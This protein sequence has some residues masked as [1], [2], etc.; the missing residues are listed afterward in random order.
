MTY[1]PLAN[2]EYAKE[3][4]ED[5][6]STT[7]LAHFG[8][9]LDDPDITNELINKVIPDK[10]PDGGES[11]GGESEGESDEDDL[12]KST[13]VSAAAP[14]FKIARIV[15][16]I[17]IFVIVI[18]LIA[19]SVVLI[20]TSPSCPPQLTWWQTAVIYQVY[21]QS[22][23][24]TDTDENIT[25][26]YGDLKGI[27]SRLDYLE[28]TLGVTAVWINPIYASPMVDNGYD[29]SDY[30][31]I[32]PL[33]G[34]MQDFDTLLDELH[35]R[36]MKLIMD[37]V[38]NHTSDQHQWFQNCINT[39][40][41]E[42]CERYVW[43]E[44]NSDGGPPNNWLS[45]FNGSAWNYSEH[46]Q[47]YYLHQFHSEQPDLNHR[48]KKV[49][50]EMKNVLKFWLDKGVDGFRVDAVPFLLEDLE[51]R[52]EP[53]NPDFNGSNDSD[54]NSLQHIYTTNVR[55]VH[56]IIEDWRKTVDCYSEPEQE[57]VFIGEVYSDV[58]TVMDYYGT[59]KKEFDFPFN[60]FLIGIQEWNATT[61]R[62]AVHKWWYALPNG[63][64]PNW[65]LGNHDNPRI[66]TRAGLNLARA[67]NLLLLTLPGTPTTYYGD[68]IGMTN[69]VDLPEDH[70]DERDAERSP[71]Q[72]NTTT[73]AG[74]SNSTPWLRVAAN[75][76]AVNVEVESNKNQSLLELFCKL[77]DLRSHNEALKYSRY[78]P[79]N[80]SGNV[81][82][83]KRD[84]EHANNVAIVLIN[85]DSVEVTED[86]SE[87]S[88]VPKRE[89][90][91][92]V[93]TLLNRTEI[94]DLSSIH[95]A[96]HEGI[97]LIGK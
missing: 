20:I 6:H 17:L 60:F 34:T 25:A 82:A 68:E 96:P 28:N 89:Y 63:A 41:S 93:S 42:Y 35:S 47:L 5:T 26:A 23:Q 58:H 70:N 39:S 9:S 22:F 16:T 53:E 85:F 30:Y 38:P 4:D 95:L 81:Y 37:F 62:D 77:I 51:F 90:Y 3:K 52:D 84:K 55:G 14:G 32:K 13:T 87:L 88:D 94:V 54:Y 97:V 8:S 59:K 27:I 79:L 45:V 19:G 67:L 18:G 11:D 83:F 66:A 56:T 69:L 74:F 76:S 91:I 65:V 72:W 2:E 61:V 24:H 73:N 57:K 21:P 40:N 44:P 7:P 86:L 48:N 80:T 75:Y 49:K 1:R 33:Y 92:A 12:H 50:E 15:L 31:T 46:R 29:I 43:R 36:N 64:W 78:I 71:M 10:E